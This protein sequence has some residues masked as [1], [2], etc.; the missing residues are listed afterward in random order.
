MTS[1]TT[2]L[3]SPEPTETVEAPVVSPDIEAASEQLKELGEGWQNLPPRDPETGKFVKKDEAP[4]EEPVAEVTEEPVETP[5]EEVAE[6]EPIEEAE[7]VEEAK[8]VVILKGLAERGEEDIE[9]AVDDPAIAERLQRLQN[10]GIRKKEYEVLRA[11][12]QAQKA[13][14][15][16]WNTAMEHNPIGTLIQAV[17]KPAALDVAKALVAEY[18]EDLFPT[19]QQMSQDPSNIYKTRLESREVAAQA[20]RQARSVSEATRRAEQILDAT[21]RLVPE[22][23][24][25]N[26]KRMFLED[27]ER[28]LVK[29]AQS[30]VAVSPETVATQL[31]DRIR[32]YGFGKSPDKPAK[33]AVARRVGTSGSA[34]AAPDVEK[35]KQ[36]QARIQA[37]AQV[38]KAAAAIPPAGRGPVATR[39]T[40]VPKGAD[41]EAASDALSKADSWAAFRPI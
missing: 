20:D 15:A 28:D 22:T 32:M 18:W 8:P 31:Q 19:L 11:E 17:P 24:A 40:L 38:R 14:I 37:N 35:A 29:L 12:V 3:P 4:V 13:E 10:D 33:P 26:I 21:A 5:A 39:K 16:E 1:D 7:P 23:V 30:G 27:A 25:P 6:E 9:L 36:V 41:I 34:T 2:N